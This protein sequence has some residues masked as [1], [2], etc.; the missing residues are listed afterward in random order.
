VTLAAELVELGVL[1]PQAMLKVSTF[2]F[3]NDKAKPLLWRRETWSVPASLVKD[4]AAATR[5][6]VALGVADAAG[7]AAYASL[8]RFMEQF[9]D[10]L[11]DVRSRGM[12]AYWAAL[13]EPFR[14]LAVGLAATDR[15]PELAWARAV[16]VS[17]RRAVERV[18]DN[19]HRRSAREL[20]ARVAAGA[21]LEAKLRPIEH[22]EEN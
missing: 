1:P 3:E 2:G 12:A 21:I 10:S 22:M 9:K 19:A 20:Q 5:L 8:S 16:A 15:G 4:E 18:T 6:V 14:R 13:D 17:A 11:E 7:K